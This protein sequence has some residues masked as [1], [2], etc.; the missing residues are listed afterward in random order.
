MLMPVRRIAELSA[1]PDRQIRYVL[2]HDL[3]P[4]LDV[5]KRGRGRSRH[6][7]PFAGFAIAVAAQ[8]LTAGLPK[9][10]VRNLMLDMGGTRT[11]RARRS[12]WR[13]WNTRNPVESVYVLNDTI[14]IRV[15][16]DQLRKDFQNAAGDDAP[17]IR[18]RRAVHA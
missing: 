8:L 7:S 11:R 6:Y 5:S 16:L 9:R 15:T 12:L 4:G 10:L 13:L 17:K 18:R 1:T 14:A 3:V 2:D